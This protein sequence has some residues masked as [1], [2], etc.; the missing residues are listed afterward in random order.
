MGSLFE[1]DLS[2]L[3]RSIEAVSGNGETPITMTLPG[4]SSKV[5]A[6]LTR[7]ADGDWMI[8]IGKCG[9][10]PEML[11]EARAVF[12]QQL[13]QGLGWQ[14][15]VPAGRLKRVQRAIAVA[16]HLKAYWGFGVEYLLSQSVRGLA[17]WIAPNDPESAP[18][19]AFAAVP[20]NWHLPRSEI[21]G[22]VTHDYGPMLA[23]P[24]LQP[25]P[26]GPAMMVLIPGPTTESVAA[27][28]E[29]LSS[30][31]LKKM[32]WKGEA[33][34]YEMPGPSRFTDKAWLGSLHRIWQDVTGP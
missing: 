18:P 33:R 13:S 22:L 16:A 23:I 7:A 6:H 32:N 24:V 34:R 28:A 19:I 26:K 20:E 14:I 31:A 2:K 15:S 9:I 30:N 29:M 12:E 3:V 21:I 17:Q 5:P 4:V 25:N 11:D 8:E 1:G 27:H 10:N